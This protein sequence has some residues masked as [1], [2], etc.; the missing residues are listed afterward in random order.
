MS[1][2]PGQMLDK[3]QGGPYSFALPIPTN[4]PIPL[5]DAE[6]DTGKFVKAILLNREKVLGARIYGATDYYTPEQI[7]TD[8]QAVKTKDGQGGGAQQLPE[9]MYKEI[10]KGTG[11]PEPFDEEMLQNMLLLP[12]FGYYGGADLKQSQTVSSVPDVS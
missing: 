7:I 5:F 4:S 10:L 1:N 8:F 2:L 9:A 11:L 12:Q 3:F 6:D